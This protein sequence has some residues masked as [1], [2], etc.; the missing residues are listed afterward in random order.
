[1][2]SKHSSIGQHF[3]EIS[4]PRSGSNIR[5]P[6][7]NIMT[8]SI[9]GAICGADN[10]V[11]I[12][13]FGIAKQDWFATFLDLRHGIPSHDTFGRVFRHL[14]PEEFQAQFSQWT[15]AMR[16][17][18]DREVISVDGKTERGSKDRA[19]GIAALEMV[20]VWASE[21]ELVLAQDRIDEGTNEITV[22]PQLL[23]L[24]DLEG[25]IVTIDAIG[26]QTEIAQ[27]IVEQGADYVLALKTNQE[28][29]FEDVALAFEPTVP[30]LPIDYHRT[31]NKG[32]GRIE[33]RDCWALSDPDILTHINAYKQW[34][35]L[36]SL[37]KVA[38]TRIENGQSSQATR[39]F[40]SSL[41]PDA[42]Q[43]LA[44]IRA[45]WQIEN[46]LHWVLDLAF[47]QDANRT[48]R[49]HAPQNLAILH[50]I[51]LNLLKQESSLKVGI[52]AKR[53]RAGWDERYLLK[54][55]ALA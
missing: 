4:D 17:K 5:H 22:I 11:D 50:H 34:P 20:S 30:S 26:C 48:R 52:K 51:A 8:I 39:Y 15:G 47:R 43:L 37:V 36:Q 45:H 10:W 31:I 7:L 24:L 14:D 28:K 40:I 13:M 35:G 3:G 27:T 38:S 32:H 33:T 23:E 42:S 2:P 16:I 18:L 12:E 19:Q 6:L 41:P 21:N 25:T 49:D 44:S 54:V 9:C 46:R 53:L 29:L 1:M 55:L